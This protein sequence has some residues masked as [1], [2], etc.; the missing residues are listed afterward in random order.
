MGG[1]GSGRRKGGIA[2]TRLDV[3]HSKLYTRTKG[4]AEGRPSLKSQKQGKTYGPNEPKR[5]KG[6]TKPKS[7]FFDVK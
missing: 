6:K 4:K 1:P 2:K 5:V 7:F 3:K